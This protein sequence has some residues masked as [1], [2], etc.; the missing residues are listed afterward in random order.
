[1]EYSVTKQQPQC[2]K[3][4]AKVANQREKR[5]G[6]GEFMGRKGGTG[7]QKSGIWNR[8]PETNPNKWKKEERSEEAQGPGAGPAVA[9]AGGG[10]G[11]ECS[12]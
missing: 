11:L 12:L 2:Q 5:S 1:M 6:E 10:L 7:G 4:G 8:K 9:G 3:A